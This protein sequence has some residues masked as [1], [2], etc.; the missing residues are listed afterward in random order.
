MRRLVV[1]TVLRGSRLV[2]LDAGTYAEEHPE[3]V[4]TGRPADLR[5]FAADLLGSER[6][7][8]LVGE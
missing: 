6:A 4:G 8:L 5:R 2:G 7:E 3:V 1:T